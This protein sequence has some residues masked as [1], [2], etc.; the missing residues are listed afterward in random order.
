MISDASLAPPRV[1]R[2][3]RRGMPAAIVDR[4]Y[5][6]YLRLKSL[7]KTAALH[8]R[9][10]QSV[11]EILH[12]RKLQLRSRRFAEKIVHDGLAYTPG[13]DGYLRATL[14]DRK[15]L[16][17]VIW[18]ASRGPVP[19]GNHLRFIDGDNRNC[20]LTNL[21]C[22]PMREVVSR[23]AR[24]HRQNQ[25][26]KARQ[27]Q[28][29]A[30][31]EP[32]LRA[33]AFRITQRNFRFALDAG[34][35]V[36]AG[37]IAVVD[38]DRL[39]TPEKCPNFAAYAIVAAKRAMVAFV[40][41]HATNVRAPGDKVFAG[42]VREQSFNA[43]I[44]HDEDSGTLEDVMGEDDR[45]LESVGEGEVRATLQRV[46]KDLPK[47]D[48]TILHARFF[49]EKTLQETGERFGISKER[50]RQIEQDA[51]AKLR[52]SRRLKTIQREEAA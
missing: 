51:L 44:G 22:L 31:L 13:K 49:E 8:G 24:G 38:A 10:R 36:Q 46:I 19:A 16:H 1:N 52:R 50:V 25:H 15:M 11:W 39:W 35:L 47:R 33:H 29:I 41:K 6:D 9:S 40:K 27:A 37:R 32:R 7:A 4:I 18:E 30:E 21:E 34:D 23:S 48:R 26:T 45:S 28:R 42:A 20:A 3:G 17:Y 14:G 12:R 5:T 43:P 2:Y